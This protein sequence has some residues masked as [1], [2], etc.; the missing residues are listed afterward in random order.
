MAGNLGPGVTRRTIDA[1]H[2]VMLSQP[3]ALAALIN[4]ALAR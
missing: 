1:G 3:G 4:E 2:M